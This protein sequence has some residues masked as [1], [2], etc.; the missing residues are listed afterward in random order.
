LAIGGLLSKQM[1]GPPAMPYQPAGLWEELAGGASMG[2]YKQGTGDDL[3]RRSIYTHRKRTVPHS[4]LS[5][6]D[7]PSF[8][9]CLARRARTNTP[10]QALTLLNDTTYVE[11]ARHLAQRMLSEVDGDA[12]ERIEYGFRLATGRRPTSTEL[13]TLTKGHA[14]YAA[15][16]GED[17]DAAAAL[18][19]NGESPVPAD[20]STDALAAYMPV[21]G[22]L[23]NLDETLTRE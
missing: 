5:S 11:A 9:Y 13:A 10:L 1:G 22:L 12:D 14:G 2:P 20:I 8:E 17:A 7:A 23:L 16:Y 15:T 6:F 21:A 19:A 18:V 4:T 3:Y